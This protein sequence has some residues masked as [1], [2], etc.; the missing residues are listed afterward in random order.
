VSPGT[1][2]EE[3]IRQIE[4]FWA[5]IGA[6]PERM[7]AGTH[8]ALMGWVS[9]VPQITASALAATLKQAGIH[10]SALG[11]GA[12]DATR[13][14]RSAPGMWRQ[15]LEQHPET[16]QDGLEAME[17]TLTRLRGLLAE[18]RLDEVEALMAETRDWL[19]SKE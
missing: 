6:E 11:P 3:R 15:I 16:L 2:Q 18:G 9:H 7:D 13:L 1:A 5:A 19:E 17:K 8:D 4:S 12:L 10:P 14:A